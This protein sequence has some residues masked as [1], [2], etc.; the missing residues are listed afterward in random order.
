MLS[1]GLPACASPNK[2]DMRTAA[3]QNPIPVVMVNCM[4]PRKANS[5]ARPTIVNAKAHAAAVNRQARE[6]RSVK[7]VDQDKAQ[8]DGKKSGEAADPEVTAKRGS[9]R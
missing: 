3:G 1:P 8:A 7:R 6:M 9:N 5:S 2:S 4:Y